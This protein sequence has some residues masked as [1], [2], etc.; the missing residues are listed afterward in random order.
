MDPAEAGFHSSFRLSRTL[1]SRIDRLRLGLEN[2]TRPI[3]VF[4]PNQQLDATQPQVRPRAARVLGAPE[5][6][7]ARSFAGAALELGVDALDEGGDDDQV[8]RGH[9]ASI[10][11]RR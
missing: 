4:A 2:L 1:S 5:R 11:I 8:V 7:D 3:R 10:P 9:D 6:L